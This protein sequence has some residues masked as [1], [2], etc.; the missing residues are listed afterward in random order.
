MS[1][2]PKCGTELPAQAAFCSNCGAAVREAALNYCRNC[3]EVLK[4]AAKFCHSCGHVVEDISA[5]AGTPAEVT[6]VEAVAETASELQKESTPSRSWPA[7]LLPLLGIPLI[8]VILWF[9]LHQKENPQLKRASD[10][11]SATEAPAPGGGMDMAAMQEVTKQI[12][13]YKNDLK[14]NPKD[15]T[16]LL[17]LG[18]MYEL[19]SLFTEAADYFRRYLE[20]A[21]NNVMV[22]MSL[23]GAY[24]SS[25]QREQALNELQQVLKYQPGYDYAMYNLGVILHEQGKHEDAIGWWHKVIEANPSGELAQKAR[26]QLKA[27]EGTSVKRDAK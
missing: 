26:E 11:I 9:L 27:F 6:E 2:C 13:K 16:A 22:R 1:Q 8:V 10:S 23:A 4:P 12:E 21:P 15:T 25:N 3:G 17:A 18:S 24:Y 7:I 14:T 5:S 20:I 19:A